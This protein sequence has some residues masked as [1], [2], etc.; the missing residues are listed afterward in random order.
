MYIEKIVTINFV[1]PYPNLLTLGVQY[2][3]NQ[4]VKKWLPFKLTCAV[5]L[6]YMV[7]SNFVWLHQ[8]LL[9]LYV[10]YT[11]N[12]AVKKWLPFEVM[13]AVYIVTLYIVPFSFIQPY[14]IYPTLYVQYT[15]NKPSK[16]GTHLSLCAEYI[17]TWNSSPL[18]IWM[19]WKIKCTWPSLAL[20]CWA[21]YL[22]KKRVVKLVRW[23]S[24]FNGATPFSF[25]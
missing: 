11:K 15:K 13:R 6:E 20:L 4:A 25:K 18:Q 7:T 17:V 10:Q 14:T 23:G 8:I 19:W 12:P 16:S 3:K 5:Y 21:E 24:V 2:T 1:R 9:T 22:I